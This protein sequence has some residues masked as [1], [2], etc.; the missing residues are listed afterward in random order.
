MKSSIGSTGTLF[1]NFGMVVYDVNPKTEKKKRLFRI[2]KHNQITNLGREAVLSLLAQDAM[3]TVLQAN[4]IYNQI[5]AIALG[6]DGTPPSITD[7][8]LYSELARYALTVP[9]GRELVVVPP[10]VFELDINYTLAP[11][12]LTGAT[13]AEAGLYTRGD[14]DDPSLA[15]NQVL[16][17]RQ[18]HPSFTI[19][20]TMSVEY[21]W[22]LGL[23]VQAP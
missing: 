13:L 19:G 16:Y 1:G 18:I 22:V 7:T 15:A 5:W 6:A 17:A 9:T 12:V 3:G 23:L 20:A 2:T 8:S 21:S 10:N 14:N 4:P 11:G